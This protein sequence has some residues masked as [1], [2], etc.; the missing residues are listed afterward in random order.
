MPFDSSS[1]VSI[2]YRARCADGGSEPDLAAAQR[3]L[4]SKILYCVT[5]I[6]LN[7]KCTEVLLEE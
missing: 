3:S 4:K 2:P 5:V 1:H 7:H 6:A